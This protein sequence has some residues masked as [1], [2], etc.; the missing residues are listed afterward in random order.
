MSIQW[1]EQ[2]GR[3]L[4]DEK[5]ELEPLFSE[6]ASRAIKEQKKLQDA[7]EWQAFMQTRGHP[8]IRKESEI[9]TY[10]TLWYIYY[11]FL[12]RLA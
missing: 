12:E 6:R 8:D 4:D 2:E 9:A 7:E 1:L 10:L 11:T 5:L 3:R